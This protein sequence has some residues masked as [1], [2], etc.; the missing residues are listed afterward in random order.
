MPSENAF[1]LVRQEK[2]RGPIV[3]PAEEKETPNLKAIRISKEQLEGVFGGMST[4]QIRQ[5]ADTLE[6]IRSL[7]AKRRTQ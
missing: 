3:S 1:E 4:E 2:M 5:N 7:F 6:E